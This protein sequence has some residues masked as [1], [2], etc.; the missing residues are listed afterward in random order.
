[1]NPEYPHKKNVLI[2][3]GS[4]FV[5][6]ELVNMLINDSSVQLHLLEHRNKL[7]VPEDNIVR[8]NLF[9]LNKNLLSKIKPDI[10]FHLGRINATS[11]GSIG[12]T[13]AALK[14]KLANEQLIKNLEE[15]D[16]PTKLIYLSG[17]L[18]YGSGYH[19][20]NANLSPVSFAR[21]Y[22]LA[23]KPFLKKRSGNLSVIMARAPWIIGNGSWF[24]SLYLD[25]I[26]KKK[27]IPQYSDDDFK[28]NLINVSECA[29]MLYFLSTQQINGVINLAPTFPVYYK[30]FIQTLSSFY[31]EIP[32]SDC[33]KDKFSSAFKEALNVEVTMR[34]NF[35]HLFNQQSFLAKSGI[36]SFKNLLNTLSENK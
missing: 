10:I 33:R 1:M 31:P 29:N 36:D 15:L 23:E 16:Y 20:E 13:Y 5:G 7:N 25:I 11:F 6:S 14:G 27:I 12:R 9:S 8:G 19:D 32:I 24:K 21:Q 3:G 35:P 34:S 22:I 28:M 30:N 26:E 18:M 2:I 17:S 4:G